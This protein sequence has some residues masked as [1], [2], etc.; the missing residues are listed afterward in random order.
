MVRARGGGS[1]RIKEIVTKLP[2]SVE[3]CTTHSYLISLYLLSVTKFLSLFSFLPI[4][5]FLYTLNPIIF[6][7]VLGRSRHTQERC[8]RHRQ[9]QKARDKLIFTTHSLPPAPTF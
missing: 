2:H 9:Q 5:F 4:L 6:S 8:Q 7:S 3:M 1:A